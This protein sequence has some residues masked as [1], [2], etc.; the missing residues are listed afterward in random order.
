MGKNQ[1]KKR[2]K[3]QRKRER[4]MIYRARLKGLRRGTREEETD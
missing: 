4:T 2:L 3:I 1:L